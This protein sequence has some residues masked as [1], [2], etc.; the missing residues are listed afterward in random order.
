[1]Q[2]AAAMMRQD[3]KDVQEV[4]VEGGDDE[5]VDRYHAAEV[6]AEE[7]LPVLGWG[8]ADSWAHVFSDGALG[9]G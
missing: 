2:N 8:P 5:E 4:K 6:I 9:N 3:N 1:V 7:S